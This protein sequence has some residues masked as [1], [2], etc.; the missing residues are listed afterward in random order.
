MSPQELFSFGKSE[1]I[2]EIKSFLVE[3]SLNPDVV[4]ISPQQAN[5]IRNFVMFMMTV[6]NGL[7]SSNL[8]NITMYDY[9]HMVC[10]H[11]STSLLLVDCVIL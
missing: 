1:K 8:K 5:D 9:H 2:Q 10:T 11:P 4:K 3:L 6:A 7:R